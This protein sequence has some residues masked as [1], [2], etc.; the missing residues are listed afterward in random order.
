[1]SVC[2]RDQIQNTEP[3]KQP[4]YK[5]IANCITQD[6]YA[7]DEV[8]ADYDAIK[9]AMGKLNN[10]AIKQEVPNVAMPLIGAGLAGGDW[11]IISKIIEREFATVQPVVYVYDEKHMHL[12]DL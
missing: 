7:S 8:H 9:I 3:L 1:M 12:L 11:D 4:V 6:F 2:V 5:F 10:F